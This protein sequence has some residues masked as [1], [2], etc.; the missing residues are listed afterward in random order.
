MSA[1][2]K[3]LMVVTVILGVAMFVFLNLTIPTMPLM[4]WQRA[5]AMQ[6]LDTANKAFFLI[7]IIGLLAYAYIK[8]LKRKYP[9][10]F[11]NLEDEAAP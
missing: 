9:D 1:V 10:I 2:P 8:H 11:N 4:P 5:E 6:L 3:P 7:I